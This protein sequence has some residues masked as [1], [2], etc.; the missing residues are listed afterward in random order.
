MGSIL[1]NINN[2]SV[3]GENLS[4]LFEP[5]IQ[6][7]ALVSVAVTLHLELNTSMALVF[8]SLGMDHA[9]LLQS[10]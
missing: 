8:R 6:S 1:G 5:G 3:P 9:L 7:D 4:A 10:I 2:G